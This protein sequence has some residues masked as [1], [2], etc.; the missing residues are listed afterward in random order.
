MLDPAHKTFQFIADW[1]TLFGVLLGAILQFAMGDKRTVKVAILIAL[2]SIFAAWFIVPALIEGA[3]VTT[4]QLLGTPE[5]IAPD[6][7]IAKAMYALSALISVEFLA[8]TIQALPVAIRART[9]Q[10]LGVDHDTI[11]K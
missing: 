4:A 1:Q 7:K 5:L 11:Q 6:G 10:F 2:S 8:F 3:N 9:K